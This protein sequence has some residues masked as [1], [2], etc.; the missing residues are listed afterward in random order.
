[1]L[2]LAREGGSGE[3][4]HLHC[5]SSSMDLR[6]LLCHWVQLPLTLLV[7]EL[8]LGHEGLVEVCLWHTGIHRE[9]TAHTAQQHMENITWREY[10]DKHVWDETDMKST[11]QSAAILQWERAF[12][13]EHRI[14][15]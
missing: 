13:M 14:S 8:L 11:C 15:S 1:M 6:H 5:A 7:C 12:W 10:Q 2:S 4:L 9:G 3:G